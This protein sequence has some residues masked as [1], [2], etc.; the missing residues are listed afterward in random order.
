[1]LV[2]KVS[3]VRPLTSIDSKTPVR[4]ALLKNDSD[5]QEH[6]QRINSVGSWVGVAAGVNDLR[7]VIAH[8]VESSLGGENRFNS[9]LKEAATLY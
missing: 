2:G 4:T 5:D 7:S 1:M 6:L 8:D 9:I 3:G